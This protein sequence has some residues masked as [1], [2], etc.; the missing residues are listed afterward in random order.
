MKLYA[1]KS[2]VS[3]LWWNE[4]RGTWTCFSDEP[5]VWHTMERLKEIQK[6]YSNVFQ[7]TSD[8]NVEIVEKE[9]K[10]AQN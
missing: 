10:D 3:G 8:H 9:V 2:K 5:G 7:S 1:E 6:F 4:E